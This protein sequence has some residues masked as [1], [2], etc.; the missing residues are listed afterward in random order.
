M[1]EKNLKGELLTRTELMTVLHRQG[2]SSVD[3]VEECV[4]EPGGTFSIKGKDPSRGDT[5]YAELVRRLESIDSRLA[6]LA[7]GKNV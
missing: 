1:V 2:F 5:Q 3:E 7:G 6:A 4:L